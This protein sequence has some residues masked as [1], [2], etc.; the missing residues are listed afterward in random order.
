[1]IDYEFRTTL[2]KEYHDLSTIEEMKELLSGSNKLFLQKF[3]L[4]DT[5]LNQD[6]HEID[7]STANTYQKIL[8]EVVKMVY[9][10]GY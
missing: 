4:R 10:R 6:L 5:C 7:A 1:M 8:S 9:L 2:V 3:V